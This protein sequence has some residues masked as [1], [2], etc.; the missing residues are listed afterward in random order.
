MKYT[1]GF[2]GTGNMGSALLRAVSQKTD[3]IA[4]SDRTQSKAKALAEEY[5]VV[6]SNNIDIA[7]N[8]KY[9][10]L[11]VK[12]QMLKE[13]IDEISPAIK[14]REDEFVLVTMAAG[15]SIGKIR[16]YVG[17]DV[18]VIRIMPNTPVAVG[19]GII[20]YCT[21]SYVKDIAEFT[22]IL[23]EAGSTDEITENLMDAASAVTGCSPAWIYM[24]IQSLA[25]GGVLCGVPRAKALMYACDSLIGA[26]EL[27]K[28]SG[29]HPEQLKDDVCSPG[30]TTIEGVNVLEKGGFRASVIDAV[31]SAYT[32]SKNMVK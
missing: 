32:K 14:A 25:D 18:P 6:H 1:V 17:K 20:L 19:K 10:F 2:I 12:P 8:A 23:S 26:A 13:L 3:S 30:G 31:N 24:F 9:I 28:K 7:Q 27:V 4:I 16:E 21:N 15:V 22:D 11:G 29:K 5:N